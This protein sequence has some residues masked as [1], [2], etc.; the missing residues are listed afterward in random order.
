LTVTPVIELNPSSLNP[1]RSNITQTDTKKSEHENKPAR[2]ADYRSSAHTDRSAG[3]DLTL[4]AAFADINIAKSTM[5][6]TVN[7]I[8]AETEIFA[9]SAKG[10]KQQF[11]IAVGRPYCVDDVSI[12]FLR[13]ANSHRFR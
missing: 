2:H 1:G 10:E 3:S 5:P 7:E 11:R 12:Y 8:I 6:E 4:Q 13:L 9:T